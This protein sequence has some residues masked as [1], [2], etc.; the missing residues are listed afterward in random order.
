MVHKFG[1]SQPVPRVEDPRLLRGGGRYVD[2]VTLPG[3]VPGYVLRSPHAHARLG[4]IDTSRAAALP[5]VLLILTAAD[6]AADGY[7]PMPRPPASPRNARNAKAVFPPRTPLAQ[8]KVRFVG[9]A[10]AF[11]VAE[12]LA[13]AKDAAELIE[14]AYEPLPSVTATA[15]AASGAAPVLFDEAPD[16][17][18]F[19]HDLGDAAAVDAGFAKAAHVVRQRFPI[20]R[21]SANTM[22]NRACICHYDPRADFFTFQA[23]LQNV[24]NIR[25]DIAE[26][27]KQPESKFRIVAEDVG[28]GFGMKGQLYPE[29]VLTAWAS[30]RLGR[31]V[32]WVAERS[33][34]LISDHHAR[35]N[36]TEAS[37][38]LDRDGRFLA[39]HVDT[40][41]SVGGY[42]GPMASGPGTNNIGSLAGVYTTPAVCVHVTGVFT[43]NNPMG[44]YRGAG[45]PEAA[46]VIE[47]LVDLASRELGIDP[48]EIRRR[49]MIPA[50]AMPFKTGLSF[51][52]DTGEFEKTMGMALEMA[53]YRGFE[54]RRAA[55]RQRGRLRGI[56]LA[57]VI[58]RAA[59]PG[60]E[61]VDIRFSP[62]GTVTV[63]TAPVDGGQGH[64]TMFTQIV[65][66]RLGVQPEMV[67]FT[68]SDSEKLAFGGGVAGSRVS[69]MGSAAALLAVDKIVAKGRKIA[70]HA[71]EAA[72]ADLVFR[73]GEFLIDGTDRRIAITEV[74]K[75]A[76]MPERLPRG[77]EAG[78]YETGTHRSDIMNFPNGCHVCELE[79][80]P[81]TGVVALCSY[82]VV[83]DVGTMINPLLVKGQIHGGVAQGL[84]QVFME[85]IVYDAESGQML[86][87]SFMDYAMPRAGDLC[88]FEVGSN[89]V[90]TPTNPLGVKGVGEAGAVGAL[91]AGVNAVVDALAHLGIRH[92]DMPLTGERLW[93]AI[94][95]ASKNS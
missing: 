9:D 53:D 73:D 69:A 81:E 8:G 12:T 49:N 10:V 22:E 75:L 44:P 87:G 79:I 45:R 61:T 16:N 24:F 63:V 64:A 40:L 38:A 71:L 32:K 43:N 6:Y 4:A 66:D 14:V 15:D 34:G 76:F 25:Q 13:I 37:L 54:A 2:D 30:R 3:T 1:I 23:G 29:Y 95:S 60:M 88:N 67:R 21:V 82:A 94:T 52:Y 93:R 89:P 68:R 83:D 20:S 7:G 91:P 72:E 50:S 80:D 90:P 31:P 62:S 18:C 26:V 77:L 65:C 74:A 92:L 28:G 48:V 85:E 46:Y 70:A 39:M 35:D 57:Y 41:V 58:E 59:P 86:T 17:I 19:I 84:G 27:F 5:G 78:L 51:T 47:R 55:A 11:I 36:V 33:E 56:G 42:A